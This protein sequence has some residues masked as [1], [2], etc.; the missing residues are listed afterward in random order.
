MFASLPVWAQ[1]PKSVQAQSAS[2]FA[3]SSSKDEQTINIQN[4][5]Y[6]F[7]ST[8]VPGRP[9]N[10][11]LVLRK[12][13]RSKA[14]IDEIG[15]EAT[16]TLEAWPLG[17]DLK[18]KP[19]YSVS[20]SGPGA[21][22]ID[23]EVWSVARGLEEVE[24]WSIYK[25]GSGQHLFDTYVPLIKFSIARD[26][27]TQRYAGLDVPPDDTADKRLK[28]PHVVAVLTYASADK[29]IREALIT[30]DD[31]KQA[32]LL[33]SFADESRALSQTDGKTLKLVFSQNFPSPPSPISM[34][35]PIVRDDLDLAHAV[36]PPRLHIAAWKR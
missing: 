31:P 24:W 4:V 22:T 5:A 8:N 1:A 30:C 14:V 23:S 19:L 32:V 35:I 16:T 26:I 15:E 12:T 27:L 17:V 7:T 13:V 25:L 11:R 20:V 36:L 29:V 6:E 9:P 3:L 33:R 28:E 18:T 10:E 21:E 34:T 2:T